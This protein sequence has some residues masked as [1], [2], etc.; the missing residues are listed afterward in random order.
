MPCSKSTC[1]YQSLNMGCS[2]YCKCSLTNCNNP[3]TI[4]SENDI[5]TNDEE[6]S[7]DE[8]EWRYFS[9][10]LYNFIFERYDKSL[11]LISNEFVYKINE[12]Y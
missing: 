9:S 3:F 7:D 11:Q 6:C 4:M 5:S 2:Q 8:E 1:G 10:I 12:H